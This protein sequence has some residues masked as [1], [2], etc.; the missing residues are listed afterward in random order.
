VY[1]TDNDKAAQLRD[2]GS[3]G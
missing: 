3:L 1:I 2:P